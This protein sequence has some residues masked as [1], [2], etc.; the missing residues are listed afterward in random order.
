MNE[1]TE[2]HIKFEEINKLNIHSDPWDNYLYYDSKFIFDI[3]FSNSF[4][5]AEEKFIQL[6]FILFIYLN[7]LSANFRKD[8]KIVSDNLIKFIQ[9]DESIGLLYKFIRKVLFKKIEPNEKE[10]EEFENK[11]EIL[12]DLFIQ[13][14]T[15]KKEFSKEKE[16]YFKV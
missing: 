6:K 7:D 5:L 8:G 16:D 1:I 11:L 3:I 15:M 14:L 12:F 10:I 2:A 9:K 4:E 13:D